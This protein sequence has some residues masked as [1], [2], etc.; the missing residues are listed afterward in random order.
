MRA[1][2]LAA[3]TVAAGAIVF[4]WG[5][6][7]RARGLA[8][9][10]RAA[11][12]RVAADAGLSACLLIATVAL[13][14]FWFQAQAFVADGASPMTMIAHVRSTT[15]GMALQGQQVAGIV[16]ALAFGLARLRRRGAWIAAS[17][18]I[19]ALTLSPAFMGH[20][21]A[22]E[23]RTWLSVG[24]DWLHVVSA[25]GW[26][27]ALALLALG[28]RRVP[29][30]ATVVI[31]AAFHRVALACV[32]GLLTTGILALLLRVQTI[33]DLPRSGYGTIFFVKMAFVAVVM[34]FGFWNSRSAE[35]RVRTGA[36][37]RA[38]FAAEVVFALAAI[39][40]TALLIGTEPPGH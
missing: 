32:T 25:G 18:A 12:E 15:W 1:V 29:A 14:R 31:I 23:D 4:R 37:V 2:T 28:A 34:V 21:I 10:N 16:G 3:V 11:L 17:V 40:T 19:A 26:V 5:V 33:G 13:P 22:A 36:S 20:P 9:D 35:S 24:A 6:L 30:A 39:I 27:G 38:S 8:T 7:G